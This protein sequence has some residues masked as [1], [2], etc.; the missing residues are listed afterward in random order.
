MTDKSKTAI[1]LTL[2]CFVISVLALLV[3]VLIGAQGG[4]GAYGMI[5]PVFLAGL[6]HLFAGPVAIYHAYKYTKLS[7]SIFIFG[8]FIFFNLVI[9]VVSNGSAI[10]YNLKFVIFCLL[11]VIYSAIK[12]LIKKKD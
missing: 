1:N 12:S 6:I 2:F 9:L 4:P 8:Y 11:P 3:A 10:L 7:I 5:L